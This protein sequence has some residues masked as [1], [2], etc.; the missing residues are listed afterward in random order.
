MPERVPHLLFN[1]QDSNPE[2]TQKH[3]RNGMLKLRKGFENISV[4]FDVNTSIVDSR[5]RYR[6]LL[7]FK[8]SQSI[9]HPKS[10]NTIGFKNC[11]KG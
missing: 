11:D 2:S 1:F 4:S 10:Q 6:P 8:V 9:I 5:E 7:G 3:R